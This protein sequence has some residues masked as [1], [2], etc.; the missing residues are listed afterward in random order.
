MGCSFK[1]DNRIFEMDG[2][3]ESINLEGRW[4]A[5][6]TGKSAITISVITDTEDKGISQE[7]SQLVKPEADVS[8]M[9]D[10]LVPMEMESYGGGWAD[11]NGEAVF[12]KTI[13][14]PASMVGKDLELHLGVIDDFDETYFNGQLVGKIDK[15]FHEFW[16]YERKYNVP[17]SLVKPGENVIA[18][19]V[20]D[21]YGNGGLLGYEKDMVL[22]IHDKPEGSGYYH[23][24]YIHGFTYGDDPYRYFRW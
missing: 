3:E 21:K 20:Y 6:L 18:I 8:T 12:R 2:P 5:K 4:L 16:G 23:P 7:A 22:K 24:D 17:A 14:V 15:N 1:N 10:K 11:A 13:D 9:E 19:R